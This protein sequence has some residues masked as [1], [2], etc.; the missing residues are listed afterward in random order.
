MTNL[1]GEEGSSL[2]T[3]SRFDA[4]SRLFPGTHSFFQRLLYIL[5]L[6][7]SIAIS[8]SNTSP[9]Q[10]STTRLIFMAEKGFLMS[11]LHTD[12]EMQIC[13]GREGKI[14]SSHPHEEER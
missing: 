14:Y 6:S 1:L 7:T 4:P 13:G 2:D 5:L 9:S 10:E 8:M 11:F 12:V 3:R